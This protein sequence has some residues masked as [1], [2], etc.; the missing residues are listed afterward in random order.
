M[1][2]LSGFVLL[3]LSTLAQAANEPLAPAEP[4]AHRPGF[5]AITRESNLAQIV[6][7]N[8]A[9]HPKWWLSGLH[10]VD[11]DGDGQLDLFLSAHGTGGAL[12]ALN[13]G[14]GHF[15]VAPGTYPGTEIHLAY[16]FDED[17]L[18]D[19]TMTHGDG[20]GQW[21]RNRSR[22][23]TLEFEATGIIRGAARRQAII[24]I[25]RDGRADWL[26]GDGAAIRFSLADHRSGFL[27]NRQPLP[28]GTSDR[29]ER[30]CLPVDIDGDGQIDLLTEWG[31]YWAPEGRSRVYR[32]AGQGK[33]IDITA[34]TGLPEQ[35]LSIKGVGDL[36]RDGLPDLICIR[37]KRLEIFLNDGRGRFT[38]QAGAFVGGDRGINA[39][40][41][42]LAVVTDFDNDGWPDILANGRHFLR[43]YRGTGDG[44]FLYM[45]DTWGIK[46]LSAAAVDDGLCFGD[47][48][49]DGRLDILGYTSLDHPRQVAV[50]RNDLP[51]QNWI[52]IRLVGQPG[53]RGAAGAKIRLYEPGT[54]RLLWYEQVLIYDS[55]A[56]A[57]YYSFAQTERHFGLGSRMAVDASV[58]FYPS[59]KVVWQRAAAA[60][61]TVVVRE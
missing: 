36:N 16:D 26:H 45:N 17:G 18:V 22:P 39:P 47:I 61:R 1:C 13:D 59:G 24:D 54:E 31:H 37:N 33:F 57:S 56:S 10:L 51:V 29:A 2:W 30:L 48:N 20:G 40:S 3:L 12:A 43:L 41:W 55:Q 14:Q 60:N 5:T 44:R 58:E 34:A 35:G 28:C 21:W 50:Y 52:N 4:G 38:Q 23:G 27:D 42:G 7:D 25:N 9:A 53:N 19:L 6:E 8:Y 46:D 11:L 32:N 15:R 49:G